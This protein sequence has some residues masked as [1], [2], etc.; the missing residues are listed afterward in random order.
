M[1]ADE[2]TGRR[3]GQGKQREKGAS[4]IWRWARPDLK[5]TR[6][7]THKSLTQLSQRLPVCLSHFIGPRGM[8]L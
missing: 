5:W 7:A 4:I 8:N 6:N 2:D 1:F 3:N